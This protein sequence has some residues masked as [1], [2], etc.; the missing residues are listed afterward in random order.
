MRDYLG[1]IMA[2]RVRGRPE[3]G[4]PSG[5]GVIS[6]TRAS[7]SQAPGEEEVDDEGSYVEEI[8]DPTD[9][10]PVDEDPTTNAELAARTRAIIRRRA[11]GVTSTG[12]IEHMPLPRGKERDAS[13]RWYNV[14]SPR[15]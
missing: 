13:G 15:R 5:E 12:G 4:T 3:E 1:E 10:D 14:K 8:E 7:L 2:A 11:H 6:Q 9:E